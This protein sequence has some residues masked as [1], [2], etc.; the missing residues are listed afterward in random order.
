MHMAKILARLL[1]FSLIITLVVS[2]VVSVVGVILG[3]DNS[4]KFSDGLFWGGAILIVSRFD[5]QYS[6]SAGNMNLAERT[7]R[8]VADMMQGYN[9]LSLF[10]MAGVLTLG[11]SVLVGSFF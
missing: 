1:L 9:M 6:Q 8:W 10:L 11:A 2:L 4:V 5:V 7:K 3:W